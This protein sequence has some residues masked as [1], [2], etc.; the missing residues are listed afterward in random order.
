MQLAFLQKQKV[1]HN[2]HTTKMIALNNKAKCMVANCNK[3]THNGTLKCASHLLE[4]REKAR[5]KYRALHG[6][7]LDAPLWPK[8]RRVESP[9]ETEDKTDYVVVFIWAIVVILLLAEI[10]YTLSKTRV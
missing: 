9:Q 6:I 10:A 2:T 5:N 1:T 8:K 4:A 3:F 7:D